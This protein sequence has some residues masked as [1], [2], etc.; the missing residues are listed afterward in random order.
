VYDGR[1]RVIYAGNEPRGRK[2]EAL[3]LAGGERR[4]EA[5]F[6]SWGWKKRKLEKDGT[7]RSGRGKT[8]LTPLN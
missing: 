4:S 3:L 1:G 5:E 6:A 8:V 7:S 2:R